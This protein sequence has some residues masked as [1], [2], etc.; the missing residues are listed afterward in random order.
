PEPWPSA[1]PRAPLGW[2]RSNRRAARLFCPAY[3]W[4][5]RVCSTRSCSGATERSQPAVRIDGT[6]AACGQNAHGQCDVPALEVGVTYTHV[7]AGWLHTVLLR[8]DG[9]AATCGQSTH[10]QCDVPALEGGVTY[11]HVAAG[12]YHTALLRSDGTVAACGQNAE[13]QCDVPALEGG[14]TYTHVA[15]GGRYTVLFRSDGTVAAFGQNEHG[16][17]DVPALEGGVVYTHAA[18]GPHHTVLLRSDG[19]VAACGQNADGQCD[20]PALEGGVTYTARLFGVKLLLQASFDGVSLRFLT[21]GGVERCR[22]LVAPGALLADVHHQ[23]LDENAAGRLGP[24]F[25]RVD[26]VLPDRLL[27]SEAS[28]DETVASVF[29]PARG[30]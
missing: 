24:G 6:V 18:A 14:V 13:G 21:L 28:V 5:P 10:G 26:A 7:A 30:G 20:V 25:D 23:L 29:G 12:Q 15:A 16:Q 11:T 19:T 9:T 22:L 17:C 27:L 2:P 8:S 3:G 4:S 1:G